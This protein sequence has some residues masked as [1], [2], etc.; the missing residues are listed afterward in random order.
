MDLQCC[1]NAIALS[2]DN[3]ACKGEE[4]TLE[5][6]DYGAG[7]TYNWT[8]KNQSGGNV[9]STAGGFSDI[10][11]TIT[12]SG[13]YDIT[14][15]INFSGGGSVSETFA[16]HL[17]IVGCNPLPSTQANWYFGKYAGLRFTSNGTIRDVNPQKFSSNTQ[18]HT[19]EGSVSMSDSMGALL[20]YGAADTSSAGGFTYR[21]FNSSYG[22][23]NLS[24]GLYGHHT[25]S[26]GTA[27]IPFG[28]AS[29]QYYIIHSS[30]SYVGTNT[31]STYYY[32]VY[33]AATQTITKRNTLLRDT[34]GISLKFTEAVS[35][36]PKC[37]DSTYWLLLAKFAQ[38]STSTNYVLYEVTKD[39]IKYHSEK[40][41]SGYKPNYGAMIKFSPDG[42]H[43]SHDKGLYQ[44]NRK[45]GQITQRYFDNDA[46]VDYVYSASFSPDSRKLYRNN[47]PTVGADKT[48]EIY[49]YDL[50]YGDITSSKRLLYSSEDF[51]AMML[52]PDSMLYLSGYQRPYVSRIEQPNKRISKDGNESVLSIGAVPLSVNG[53]GGVGTT[54]FPNHREGK[55]D[56][57]IA[58]DFRYTVDNCSVVA[59]ESNQ[60][61]ASNYLWNFGDGNT[62]TLKNPS[63]TYTANG[64]YTVS[65]TTDGETVSKTI[66]LELPASQLSINGATT[67]CDTT[68]VYEYAVSELNPD[69]TY[70]W[71]TNSGQISYG[72][73]KYQTGVIWSD[74]DVLSLTLKNEKDACEA[75][76]SLQI[77]KEVGEPINNSIGTSQ[78]VCSEEFINELT[79]VE[80]RTDVSYQWYRKLPQATSWTILM[81]ETNANH[82]PSNIDS[83]MEYLLVAT[84]GCNVVES[85][86]VQVRVVRITNTITRA[87]P[88]Y[89]HSGSNLNCNN[90]GADGSINSFF[91][92]SISYKWEISDRDSNLSFSDWHTDHS[93]LDGVNVRVNSY[94]ED[95]FGLKLR[96]IIEYGSCSDTSNEVFLAQGFVIDGIDDTLVC[97]VNNGVKLKANFQNHP[98]LAV[99]GIWTS[100]YDTLLDKVYTTDEIEYQLQ[101]NN[102]FVKHIKLSLFWW[103]NDTI[104]AYYSPFCTWGY[105]TYSKKVKVSFNNSLPN[106]TMQPQS[107]TYSLGHNGAIFSVSVSNPIGAKYLWQTS[108]DNGWS[109]SNT[110]ANS[111]VY[112]IPTLEECHDGMM[113]R[114]KITN[115]CGTVT[116][117]TATLT[118]TGASSSTGAD[119]WMRD[120]YSDVGNE[121]NWSITS[122]NMQTHMFMSPD[123]WNRTIRPVGNNYNKTHQNPE[124]R[125]D[126]FNFLHY[127][128]RN[129]GTVT[130]DSE[131]LYLYWTWGSTA[132]IWKKDWFNTSQN[133][134]YNVDSSMNYPM[135]SQI[136]TTPIKIPP[137]APGD[138]FTFYAEWQP[139]HPHWYYTYVNGNKEYV[140]KETGL[141][142]CVL[143]RI[144]H[145]NQYPHG[146]TIAEHIDTLVRVNVQNNNNIVTRNLRVIDKKGGNEFVGKGGWTKLPTNCEEPEIIKL[147]IHS[148]DELLQYYDV[149]LTIDD[150]FKQGINPVNT[151]GLQ[152][153][154]NNH[155]SIVDS[156]AE[157]FGL[158]LDTCQNALYKLE[159][160]PKIPI[161]DIPKKRFTL[162]TDQFAGTETI[163]QGVMVFEV[164]NLTWYEEATANGENINAPVYE[165]WLSPNP[166]PNSFT[167]QLEDEAKNIY[168][169]QQGTI[170]LSD[171]YGYPHIQLDNIDAGAITNINL[172]GYK[173]GV[174]NIRFEIGGNV[175]YKYLVKTD[176]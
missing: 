73:G 95:G 66:V 18:I 108:T 53:V 122:G 126:S 86:I 109:W 94:G 119:V 111:S 42:T 120:S 56:V 175:F 162:Y 19:N 160:L 145:C 104:P 1:V 130:S 138:S 26:Q 103:L 31:S 65:I 84:K 72:Q 2:G 125:P 12:N 136:N 22:D 85:N 76:L 115:A 48:P 4:F 57:E 68:Q 13:L 3:I 133:Q 129:R 139:P 14:L 55:F 58:P 135:G 166:T 21:L 52:G 173:A 34:L 172:T 124:Y 16:K 54:S 156:L 158:Q 105:G 141:S 67:F 140:T 127:T 32:S 64:T 163:P 39:T 159:F 167:V 91:N 38:G 171:G 121:P 93:N 75:S 43:F 36:L 144:E 71:S 74:S 118:V 47:I 8:I 33:D 69:Y 143:A 114:C 79:S 23:I 155:Y 92:L 62:S 116:S 107:R 148:T 24:G 152:S 165:L 147:K 83:I 101:T 97:G 168:I 134:F 46:D 80:P 49:Q 61:C 153:V 20:F 149:L 113:F 60:C 169:G 99:R 89:S 51:N 81:G 150:V 100:G 63:H 151:I 9:Y 157:I 164:D 27:L 87:T 78:V 117:N 90:V 59:F 112:S 154:S 77:T 88:F 170:V 15:S 98:D 45:T 30:A 28:T 131:N 102:A 146:M 128:I 50:E 96:R 40:V 11:T 174:Y 161:E 123:L 35:V 10:K 176:E 70:T 5:T 106:I 25:A 137:I 132:E 17:E 44:F 7:T 37:G 142:I 41:F 82:T 110:G 29:T 6:Y